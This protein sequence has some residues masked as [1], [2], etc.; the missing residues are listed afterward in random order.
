MDCLARMDGWMYVL[1]ILVYGKQR[2]LLQ[3]HTL[4]T[5]EGPFLVYHVRNDHV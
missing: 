4:T 2:P 5:K 1:T 3:C